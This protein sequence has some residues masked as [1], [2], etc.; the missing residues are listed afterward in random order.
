MAL[1][2]R[3][4]GR[5]STSGEEGWWETVTCDGS[6]EKVTVTWDGSAEEE[7]VT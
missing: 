3:N 4:G 7:T 6:A 5:Q 1:L 2:R